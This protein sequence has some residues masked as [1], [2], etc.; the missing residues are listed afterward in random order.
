MSNVTCPFKLRLF[1]LAFLL[2]LLW[3]FLSPQA[4]A[5]D[6]S[7]IIVISIE[8]LTINDINAEKMPNL[9]Q[10]AEKNA[11]GLMNPKTA[12]RYDREHAFM[13]LGAGRPSV[14]YKESGMAFETE[15]QVGN[16]DADRIY[17]SRTGKEAPEGGIV[18]LPLQPNLELNQRYK[19]GSTPGLLGETLK[20][21]G[22]S[23]A[24]IGNADLP[25]EYH[26]EAVA[27]VM[28]KWGRVE[29]GMVG[30]ELVTGGSTLL[31]RTDFA[32]AYQATLRF[33]QEDLLLVETGDL[34]RLEII[35][36]EVLPVL[37]G[38]ERKQ[39]LERIDNYIGR[40]V[41][42]P[43][44]KNHIL[45]VMSPR[46]SKASQ[47]SKNFF[48]P[49]IIRGQ[50]LEGLL[51]SGT[52]RRRGIVV[53]TDITASLLKWLN[54]SPPGSF[55]GRPLAAVPGSN[56]QN[57]LAQQNEKAVFVYNVRPLLVK[58]YV[59]SQIVIIF[60]TLAALLLPIPIRRWLRPL[61]LALMAVP[62]SLLAVPLITVGNI[63][64]YVLA[65]TLLVAGLVVLASRLGS[66]E[67]DGIILL[68]FLTGL[69]IAGDVIVGAPL[70]KQSTL[71]YDAMAGARYYGIGNEYMGVLVGA[72]IVGTTSLLQRVGKVSRGALLSLAALY[73]FMVGIIAAPQLGTNFGGTLASLAAFS[74]VIFGIWRQSIKYRWMLVLALVS[75]TAVLAL[76][77]YDLAR[78]TS[79]QSHFGRT[80]GHVLSNGPTVLAEIAMRKIN[81]NIKLIKWTI[82][83]RV[84]LAFLITII[85]LSLRPVGLLRLIAKEYPYFY[86]GLVA[87]TVGSG[88]ALAT[89]D[90]GIVAAATMMIFAAAPLLYVAVGIKADS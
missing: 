40:L 14:G 27:M 78:P 35:K 6:T 83:S 68:C 42:Q 55:T 15:E 50:Q 90:S 46:P 25:G 24:I 43:K 60:L 32:Q 20:Q 72:V 76:G 4:Y 71:G 48:T 38:E 59:F 57:W 33:S 80:I 75:L 9:Y 56:K 53:N 87:V 64:S 8:G 3:G 82:W 84:F 51:T 89:N 2:L 30:K 62:F 18:Y 12:S 81:M 49:L 41:G 36:D 22:L 37:W 7:P 19:T 65:I 54:V 34:T 11:L 13:T 23:A 88:V 85:V 77:L 1:L 61:L 67:L 86:R 66:H 44:L 29:K 74:M 73:L 5:Q 31:W 16:I 26:R 52:T 39:A 79:A 45:V 21:T 17:T 63:I 58:S 28:D 69:L 10:L 47:E 70:M